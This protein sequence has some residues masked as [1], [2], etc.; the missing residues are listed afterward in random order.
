MTDE[1]FRAAE[2]GEGPRPP[3]RRRGLAAALIVLTAV[4]AALTHATA[5][6]PGEAKRESPRVLTPEESQSG[7]ARLSVSLAERPQ[8]VRVAVLAASFPYRAQVEEFRNKLRLPSVEAVLGEGNPAPSFRFLGVNVERRQLDRTGKPLTGYRPVDIAAAYR[9]LLLQAGK[10]FEPDGPR[11]QS[12]IFPGLVMPRLAAVR[13]RD[14]GREGGPYPAVEAR[15][16]KLQQ[17][18]KQLP[19]AAATPQAPRPAEDFN[20]FADRAPPKETTRAQA[21][22]PAVLP[23]YC[24]LRVLDPTVQP[25]R[26]YQYRLQVRMANPNYGRKDVAAPGLADAREIRSDWYEVPQKVVSPE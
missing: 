2:Q 15:L 22:T 14:E 7:F 10:R 5:Q 9:P 11:L 23:R 3:S 12:V 13:G 20:P 18:L 16:T 8:P 21:A 6:P 1:P 17:S 26:T 4:S 24:L 25:G 19:P